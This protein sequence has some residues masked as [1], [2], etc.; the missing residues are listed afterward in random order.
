M[1]VEEF[2]RVL[3]LCAAEKMCRM[4]TDSGKMRSVIYETST[5]AAAMSVKVFSAGC[6]LGDA[7]QSGPWHSAGAEADAEGGEPKG[8]TLSS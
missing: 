8:G 1:H 4:Q 3:R 5:S 6:A 7:S 2:A